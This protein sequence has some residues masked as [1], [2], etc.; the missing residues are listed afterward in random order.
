[1]EFM[2]PLP[3]CKVEAK[4]IEG[5]EFL[6]SF[7]CGRIIFIGKVILFH[8]VK[9]MVEGNKS[10]PRIS[11]KGKLKMGSEAPFFNFFY[12]PHRGDGVNYFVAAPNKRGMIHARPSSFGDLK[13]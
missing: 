6:Y 2:S 11:D 1:M 12:S 9:I 13:E 10:I 7:N 4:I 3:V 5:F 8:V